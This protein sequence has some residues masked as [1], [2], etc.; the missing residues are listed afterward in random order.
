MNSKQYLSSNATLR[1]VSKRPA[2]TARGGVKRHHE[3]ARLA[4]ARLA[5]VGRALRAR[6]LVAQW[7]TQ[8][9]NNLADGLFGYRMVLGERHDAAELLEKLATSVLPAAWVEQESLRFRPF[10]AGPWHHKCGIHVGDL[11]REGGLRDRRETNVTF[12][13]T[14]SARRYG[15]PPPRCPRRARRPGCARPWR[16]SINHYSL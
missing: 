2:V 12:T 7:S 3:V 5:T 13:F 16:T 1:A 9:Y 10:W 4:A 8:E 14:F 15:P 6:H 11:S